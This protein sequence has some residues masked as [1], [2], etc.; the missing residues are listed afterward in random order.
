MS[1]RTTWSGLCA[2]TAGLCLLGGMV[3]PVV[4]TLAVAAAAA[5]IPWAARLPRLRRLVRP[6]LRA[7][8]TALVAAAALGTALGG[9]LVADA[10]AATGAG[11]VCLLLA[12]DPLLGDTGRPVRRRE[13]VT[14]AAPGR[15]IPAPAPVATA[16]PALD[17]LC[18]AWRRSYLELQRA[19]DDRLWH[20][21]VEAR[22]GYLDDLERRDPR[23]FAR[24]LRSGA[25]AAG[26]PQRFLHAAE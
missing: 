8:T 2:G 15:S 7:R 6:P 23:G 16:Q 21:V 24:W 25:R 20:A 9:L 22:R 10:V 11:A 13:R 19:G 1:T 5:S 14:R 12:L 3:L 17:D 26:D 4:F 18:L